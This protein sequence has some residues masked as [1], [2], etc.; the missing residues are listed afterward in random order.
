MFGKYDIK[1][2]F[3]INSGFLGNKHEL[4]FDGKT[5]NHSEVD[6]DELNSIYQGHEIAVHTLTHK[7]LT[8]INEDEIIY[9]VETDRKNLEQ[10]TGNEI[11]G[12]AYPCGGINNNDFT[13]EVLKNKTKIKYSRTITSSYSFDIE[14]NLYRFNPTLHQSD[15]RLFEIAQ[16]FIN[17]N[18]EGLKI[19]YI[20]GHSYELDV[21][22][23]WKKIEDFL[24]FISGKEDIF[25]GTNKEI[26]L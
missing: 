22:E 5:V 4:V 14:N 9:Q 25:Y 21:N 20:W 24:K 3:N 7:N 8:T 16:K 26:L 18:P 11:V 6:K 19:F 1:A 12:M 15:K 10:I 17:L 13:A 23:G 2:T